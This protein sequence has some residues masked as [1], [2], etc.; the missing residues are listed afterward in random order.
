ML[1]RKQVSMRLLARRQQL[2]LTQ[3]AVAAAAEL[4]TETVR[5]LER[6]VIKSSLFTFCRVAE[7]L[8]TTPSVLLAETFSDEVADLVQQ[9]PDGEQELAVVILRAMSDHVSTRP[10]GRE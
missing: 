3:E 4:S 9:L 1:T 2:G 6:G 10:R 7:A 5:R 8:R